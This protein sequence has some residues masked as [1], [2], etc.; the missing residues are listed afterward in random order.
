MD[1][2]PDVLALP[3]REDIIIRGAHAV[4]MDAT[5]GD[6]DSIDIAISDGRIV[7]LGSGLEARGARIVDGTGMVAL[8]G[9]VDT[10]THLWSGLFRSLTRDGAPGG[11]NEQKARLGPQF[12]P[13]ETYWATFYGLVEAVNSGVTTIHNWAHNLRCPEDADASVAAQMHLGMRGRFSYGAAEGL[14]PSQ[15]IDLDDVARVRSAWFGADGAELI[16]LGMALRGPA[17]TP[18]P[19]YREEWQAARALALPV[20]I[21]YA[22]YPEEV[23]RIDVLAALDAVGLLDVDLQLVHCLFSTPA[24]RKLIRSI[25][26]SVSCAPLAVLRHGLGIPP[27]RELLGDQLQVSLSLDTSSLAGSFDMFSLM[28]TLLMVEHGQAR[29]DTGLDARTVLGLA[30]IEGARDLDIDHLTGSLTPGKRADILLVDLQGLNSQPIVM[31]A[32]RAEVDLCSVLV[33]S[34]GPSNVSS[35]IVDGRVLKHGGV[36][37]AVDSGALAAHARSALSSLLARA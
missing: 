4:T 1:P 11:Y 12:R 25:G 18:E 10:H 2:D 9:F 32:D 22:S 24:D 8:P 14:A 5:L 3:E 33:Y 15:T 31:D 37:T 29:D 23:A 7:E 6:F 28:R 35:V 20:T 36:L 34:C 19:V 26:A 27:I 13:E 21:H 17:L 30:T 16:D